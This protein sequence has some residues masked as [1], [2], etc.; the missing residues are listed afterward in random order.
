VR[1]ASDLSEP[2]PLD[3]PR[4][5][6]RSRGPTSPVSEPNERSP[7]AKRHTGYPDS[8]PTQFHRDEPHTGIVRLPDLP[9]AQRIALMERV[10]ERYADALADGAMLTVGA[11]H[12]R[13]SRPDPAVD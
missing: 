9:A 11:D 6:P 10:I 8:S 5:L 3:L 13:I 1:T 12:V 7:S 2:S 4:P